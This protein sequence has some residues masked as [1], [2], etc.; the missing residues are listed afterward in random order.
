[1]AAAAL[2]VVAMLLL[3]APGA[4]AAAGAV[5]PPAPAYVPQSLLDAATANPDQLFRVIVQ[6]RPTA[7]ASGVE[8]PV[9]QALTAL[10]ATGDGVND[11]FS[12]INAVAAELS[13]DQIQL[14]AGSS[15]ILAITPDA[16]LRASV[17]DPPVVLEP[18]VVTGAA[19]TGG[20]LSA[21]TGQWSGA[22]ATY[23]YQW[24]RCDATGACVEVTGAVDST[25]APTADDLGSTLVV[26]VTATNGDGTATSSSAPTV[27]VAAPAPVAQIAPPSALSSPIVTG[28]AVAGETLGVDDGIWSSTTLAFSV[29]WQRCSAAGDACVEIPGAVKPT[30]T[31]GPEDVGFTF[32]VA[33][34]GTDA[35]GS[36]TA[37]SAATAVV[38]AAPAAP[39]PTPPTELT[40]PVLTGTATAG[41]TLTADDGTWSGVVVSLTRQWQRCLADGTCVD[42]PGAVASTYVLGAGDVGST[43][44]IVVTATDGSASAAAMSAATSVVVDAAPA[45]ATVTV[46]PGTT[47]VTGST[48]GSGTGGTGGGLSAPQAPPTNLTLPTADGTPVAQSDLTA[49]PGTWKGDDA[50]QYAYSWQRCD[51]T[52][53]GVCSPVAST[54]TYT[55]SSADVGSTLQVLVTATDNDAQ[56]GTATSA[57]TPRIAPYSPS[58]FWSWQLGP[59][60][61]NVDAQWTAVAAAQAKPPAIAVVDSGVDPNLPGLDGT[62]TDSVSLTTLPQ[63]TAADGYGHG[64]FVAQVAAG[65][66]KGNAGAAPTASIVSID[67][68]DDDGMALTSDVVAAA[69]WIYTH[70]SVDNIGVAN[71]SLLGSS[72]TS[73]NFDPLDRAIEQLWLSG[74]VV[75]TAVGNYAVNGA[76]SDV[77]FAP[78]NDPFVITVGASDPA[79]TASPSDD[80]AAPWSAYGHTPDGFGKP[81]LGAT[82]RYIVENV[83][84]DSTLYTSRPGAVVGPG[85][86]QLSGTSFAAPLVSGIAANLLALHPTWTPD[87]VKGALM[88]SAAQPSAATGFALGVGVVDAA[89]ALGVVDPPNANAAI[90][91]FVVPDPAGGATPI[92]DTA[93]WGTTARAD[94]SWGTASWGTASWGTASWGTASWGTA[95]WSAASWGT[96]SW[97]TA[98]WDAASWGTASWGTASWGTASWGTDNANADVRP[99][100]AFPAR[101]A[102]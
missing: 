95:Y 39:A 22:Q 16:A 66:A 40:P 59:Y 90:D 15:R 3:F 1:M 5:P 24:Q 13:G 54:Q 82:G 78:A 20:L 92:F 88:L 93:S 99:L 64:S 58:G 84:T 19:E 43:V 76:V 33:V 29:Q 87:K 73:V 23:T 62:V 63:R 10:P 6:G 65:H 67:V 45:T 85:R 52:G 2:A 14:L 35:L 61:A 50:L 91:Q 31:L 68:M 94:A 7:S 77:P 60:A 98:A 25:F 4:T 8:A 100:A 17:L 18:P 97:G 102:P 51:A 41:Q 55:L 83:P 36:S 34:T 27:V 89:A 75:V 71:F 38:S 80:F 26:F 12:S 42:I 74:V 96:A 28:S 79:D 86:M 70:K 30:Y 48:G 37:V 49:T 81:E 46:D 21:S 56:V 69:D 9:T 72:R 57:P 47:G 32:K 101:W 44:R 53:G 11:T